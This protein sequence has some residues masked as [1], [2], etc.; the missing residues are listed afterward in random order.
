MKRGGIDVEV[1]ND[2]IRKYSNSEW[3]M[4]NKELKNC[5]ELQPGELEI[6][7]DL[8]NMTQAESLKK[9]TVKTLG[10]D[11]YQGLV[12]LEPYF[13][14]FS[15]LSASAYLNYVFL[16]L[17]N[18][19]KEF[20]QLRRCCVQQPIYAMTATHVLVNTIL[21]VLSTEKGQALLQQNQAL[22]QLEQ[23]LEQQS[24]QIESLKQYQQ[25]YP[26]KSVQSNLEHLQKNKNDLKALYEKRK[27]EWCE[28]LKHT[29]FIKECVKNLTEAMI[30][31]EQSL[32][33]A[34]QL[35]KTW[36]IGEGQH[37]RIPMS[38]K[39][40]MINRL[41]S[42]KKFKELNQ[43]LGRFQ[44]VLKKSTPSKTQS[45]GSSIHS[46]EL[47][48]QLES[49]LPSDKMKLN[50]SVLK[51]DFYQRY[52]SKQLIQYKKKKDKPRGKGPIIACI[53]CSGSMEGDNELWSK[54]VG[55]AMLQ[56]AKQQRRTFIGILY[57][58]R[59]DYVLTAKNGNVDGN[60][61]LEF[62]EQFSGGGTEF[63]AP[64][65]KA[66]EVIKR[67][68]LEQADILF[69][70]DGIA[71]LDKLFLKQFKEFK[72]ALNCRCV[73]IAL[74]DKATSN[75]SILS[76]FCDEVIEM[77]SLIELNQSAQKTAQ[78]INQFRI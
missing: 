38:Q 77:D 20:K 33:E 16:S 71:Y 48:N 70:S 45:N 42:S 55:L 73:G 35:E 7:H 3:K 58:N 44:E 17:L 40:E 59:L 34:R 8:V 10:E 21:K 9:P 74:K 52:L 24:K 15:A 68:S 65:K 50:H 43:I 29:P 5:I 31:S 64:L 53:D 69:I 39:S 78:L 67:E 19:K 51:K 60:E 26:E 47:G 49:V 4:L 57:S 11:V 75:P 23:Q 63:R 30:Q 12:K 18:Q 61:L 62:A 28:Y 27:D 13:V 32:T 2:S 36:G 46:V 56:L 54:A 72:T 6:Y 66:M 76:D 37:R 41:Q 22:E 25:F 14:P 1:N